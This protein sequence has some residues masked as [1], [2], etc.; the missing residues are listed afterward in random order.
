ML[1]LVALY[2]GDVAGSDFGSGVAVAVADADVVGSEV[3]VDGSGGA[4]FG[5]GSGGADYFDECLVDFHILYW[6][7]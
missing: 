6:S 4:G 1:Y 3:G 7:E 5:I 2:V